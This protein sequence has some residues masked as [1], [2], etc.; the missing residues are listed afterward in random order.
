MPKEKSRI[1]SQPTKEAAQSKPEFSRVTDRETDEVLWLISVERTNF[2]PGQ[3]VLIAGSGFHLN[4]ESELHALGLNLVIIDQSL[5]FTS[6]DYSI[7]V[8]THGENNYEVATYALKEK[9]PYYGNQ[10]DP[11]FDKIQEERLRKAN[12]LC[13][14]IITQ[15]VPSPMLN[16]IQ[17]LDGNCTRL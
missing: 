3:K 13:S 17:D 12:A 7:N 11:N 2:F 14:A 15:R 10:T 4:F 5:G 8:D 16:E 9:S 1:D 6:T